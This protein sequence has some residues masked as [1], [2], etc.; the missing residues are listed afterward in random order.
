MGC[1]G[2]AKTPGNMETRE[3]RNILTPA[4]PSR[5][6]SEDKDRRSL[7]TED[8]EGTEENQNAFLCVLCGLALPLL[9]FLSY[10]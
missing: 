7:T 2:V 6:P 8:T 4:R 1:Y 9:L 3:E 5:N 10:V